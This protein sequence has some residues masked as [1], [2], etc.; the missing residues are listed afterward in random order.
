MISQTVGPSITFQIGRTPSCK[1]QWLACLRVFHL[2]SWV[3]SSI[4]QTI[5]VQLKSHKLSNFAKERVC[6][7]WRHRRVITSM[8]KRPSRFLLSKHWKDRQRCK[9]IWIKVRKRC[10]RSKGRTEWSS[11]NS[12]RHKK[13]ASTKRN[14]AS[15]DKT[16][17]FPT[18]KLRIFCPVRL[19][20][21][22]AT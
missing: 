19:F 1:N 21:S 6:S 17:Y 3:R 9:R 5:V 22:Y 4:W 15:A 8:L 11:Q 20:I 16:D 14:S 7:F 13:R 2:W 18:P 12:S 10:G